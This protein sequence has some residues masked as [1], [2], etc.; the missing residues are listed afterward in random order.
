MKTRNMGT[1]L[2][3]KRICNQ[4]RTTLIIIIIIII[5]IIKQTDREITVNRPNIIFKSKKRKHAH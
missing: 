4:Y 1:I 5:I 3:F 2:K